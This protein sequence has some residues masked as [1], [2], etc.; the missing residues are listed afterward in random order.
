MGYIRLSF[1][2][3]LVLV[4]LSQRIRLTA[5]SEVNLTFGSDFSQDLNEAVVFGG[6]IRMIGS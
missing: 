4:L 3:N 2:Q 5:L 6:I 1:N